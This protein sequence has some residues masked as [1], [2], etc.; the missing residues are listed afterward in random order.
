MQ[1]SLRFPIAFIRAIAVFFG[2]NMSA[3]HG[4]HGG[5]GG[6]RPFLEEASKEVWVSLFD[7]LEFF[8]VGILGMFDMPMTAASQ[9]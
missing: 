6:E 4:G 9:V 2:L 8:I 7:F 3:E 5:G 1:Q